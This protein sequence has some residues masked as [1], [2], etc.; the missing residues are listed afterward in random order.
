M[1]DESLIEE[2][3]DQWDELQSSGQTP[4][5]AELCR[6][7]PQLRERLEKTIQAFQAMNRA[8]RETVSGT[9]DSP[10]AE[11]P[12]K[13]NDLTD[14]VVSCEAQYRVLRSHAR[15]GLGEVLIAHDD[16]IGRFVAIKRIPT[17]I[18]QDDRRVRRLQREAAITGQLDHPGVVSLLNIGVDSRGAPCYATKFVEGETLAE[19]AR[20]RH[21]EFSSLDRSDRKTFEIEILR[22]LLVRFIAACNTLAYAHSRSIVHRD[23]KPANIMVGEFGATYVVDWGLARVLPNEHNAQSGTAQPIVSGLETMVQGDSATEDEGAVEF[24]EVLTQTGTVM[25]TPAFMSPEQASGDQHHVG[26]SSDIYSLGATLWFLLTG[27]AAII[28]AGDLKWLDQLRKGI[29]PKPSSVQPRIPSALDSICLKA[30]SLN[31][32]DRYA[33]ALDLALDLERWMADERVLAHAESPIETAGR[34]SRR[35]R[36][37]TQ[38]GTIALALITALSIVFAVVLNDRRKQA[39]SAEK[40]SA[41]LAKDKSQLAD[42]KSRLAESEAIARKSADEQGNLALSTLRSVIFRIS[43]NLEDVEGASEVRL[44]LL[45]TAVDGLGKVATTLDSRTEATRDLMVAH[46]DLGKIYVSAGSLE[47]VNTTA[48]ALRQFQKSNEI[49]RLLLVQNPADDV[50]QRDMSVSW[51]LMG[52]VLLQMGELQQA[53]DAFAE[54]LSISEQRLKARPDEISRRQ[55]AGYGYEKVGDILAA[56]G[57]LD[58]AHKRYVRSHDLYLQNAVAEPRKPLH[59]R[60]VLVAISKIGNIQRRQGKLDEAAATFQ[61]CV[62]TC[63]VLEQIPDSGAQRR[64]RSI[65]LNKLGSVLTEQSKLK[66]ATAAFEEGLAIARECVRLEPQGTLARRD[67]ATSLRYLG[68]VQQKSADIQ[69]ARKSWE[70]CLAIRRVLAMEDPSS[71]VA[72]VELASI[73]TNLGELDHA[74][75]QNDAARTF[76]TEAWTLLTGLND[77]GRLQ[78]V[79]DQALMKRV[80]DLIA[81]LRE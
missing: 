16:Q 34:M 36:A 51:E 66:E 37:W 59:R 78:G 26:Q 22:P 15:G 40:K 53:D 50:L 31:P 74:E 58:E 10:E 75:Q 25:G 35:Y 11:S 45:N 18:R 14:S 28:S 9:A 42:E 68:D 77:T 4:D 3:L 2:L 43:R 48:E 61:A 38:A 24:S 17:E 23:V 76:L 60:D 32:A 62:E 21:S 67:L 7:H 63:K 8:L 52:D 64:D 70:E 80:T 69:A 39:E 33:T 27:R 41:V 55:D 13:A 49:G 6:H 44:Q 73:L 72:Q 65:N 46:N 12:P 81:E 19:L 1:N 54:S 71:Q 30:M 56:R 79:E 20:R 57:S 29:I 5:L 47:K